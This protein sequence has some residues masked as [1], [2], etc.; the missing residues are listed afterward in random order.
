MS[1]GMEVRENE[2]YTSEEVKHLLKISQSTFLRLVKKGVLRAAKVGGQYRILGKEILN[3]V[4]PKLEQ[5][6][7]RA[8]QLVRSRVKRQLER[9]GR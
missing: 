2:I 4:S 3:L 9:I 7:A 5:K 6:A 8:Y 1:S